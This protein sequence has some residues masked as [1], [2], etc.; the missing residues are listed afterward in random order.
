MTKVKI[1]GITT[2][3]DARYASGA[4]A[5]YLGFIQFEGSPRYV[6]PDVARDI[7]NWVYGSKPVGVF[8]NED[9]E[10]VNE[11]CE[12]AGFDYVQLHGDETPTYCQ[13]MDRPVIK[14]IRVG[15]GDTSKTIQDQIDAFAEV[16]EYILLDTATSSESEHPTFGGTGASFDWSILQQVS[17]PLPIFLAGGLR[18]ETAAKAIRE[19]SPYA[20]DV[21]S[22]VEESAGRKDFEKIDTFMSEV[23]GG[24]HHD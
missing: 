12:L 16:A 8:V 24:G 7:I 18:S 6:A 4:G 5:D 15:P 11:I 1:C 3:A 14:A 17:S 19:V 13:W 23:R 21:S 22:G 20:L 2:L 9:A 10:R